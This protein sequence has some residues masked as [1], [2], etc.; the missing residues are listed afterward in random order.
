MSAGPSTPFSI[1]ISKLTPTVSI[2][3][4]SPTASLGSTFTFTTTVSGP[5]LGATPTGTANWSIAGVSGI[6]CDST[7]GPTGTGNSV[8][9]TCSVTASSAGIYIP[10]FS[11]NGDSNYL[12]TSPTSGSTTTVSQT[13]PVISVVANSGTASLGSTISFT[14]TAAGPNG[15]SAPTTGGTWAITG[16]TGVTSCTTTTG[17]VQN[18]NVST[19]TCS[20]IAG[21]TGTYSATFTFT[22]GGAYNPM[23][24]VASSSSTTVS[25]A[26]PTISLTSSGT[27]TLGGSLT[28]TT[29][30]TG[31]NNSVAPTGTVNWAIS[32]TA[33]VTSCSSTGGPS[34]SGNVTTYTCTVTTSQ[35]G[36]YIAQ[37]NFLGDSNYAAISS[38]AVTSTIAKQFPTISVTAS[39]NP[40]LG[41]TTTLTTTVTGVANAVAPSGAVSWTITDPNSAT[42]YCTNPTG[43]VA[44]FNVLTYTCSFTTST[45]GIYHVSSTVASDTN[46]QAATSSTIS[47]NLS[48]ATPTI[49]LSAT[50]ANPTVGQAITFAALVTGVNGLPAPTGTITWSVTGQ[51]TA[52]TSTSNPASGPS[53]ALFNCIISTPSEGTYTV[54]ATY[55]GDTT[56]ASLPATSP[57]SVVVGRATPT[58]AVTSSPATPI[59]GN[60]ITYTAT[61]TG[62][63]GATAPAGSITWGVSGQTTTC[64]TTTGPLPGTDPNQTVFTCLVPATSAGTYAATATYSG[65]TNYTAL[66]A[67][68]PVNVSIGKVSPSGNIVLTGN[69]SGALNS[70][71]LF[72][73]IVTGSGGPAPTGAVTWNVSGSAGITSCTSTPTATTVGNITTYICNIT[74]ANYGTYTV[75]AFYGGDTNYLSGTS[76]S[77]TLGISVLSSND[78]HCGII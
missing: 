28:F 43:P 54:T 25:S 32:G 75:S 44:V 41:G 3:T 16:V 37:A 50:P 11:F 65:D 59:L 45:A 20:V 47:V 78:E 70:N 38:T 36:T 42:I 24:A 31:A 29:T 4:S 58:I 61:V 27:P 5:T 71:L 68:T 51:A 9:Y 52:C 46:Y 18:S 19:Y 73:A 30:V 62:I 69:G 39:A 7:T 21:V 23:T 17:P 60:T 2:A 63:T 48:V 76:N 66:S 56:Y 22:G 53:T 34:S 14:A 49:Y 8:T 6:S 55:N 10:L 57:V 35:V 40:S 74:A 33:G 12:A 67:T 15:A 13:A 1:V 26:T 77:V 72:T 64:A